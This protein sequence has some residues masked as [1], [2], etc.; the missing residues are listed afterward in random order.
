M[1]MVSA[2]GGP[3]LVLLPGL[4]CDEALWGHPARYLA[5]IAQITV[6]GIHH[7]DNIIDLA[8]AVLEEAPA[9]FA[10]AGLSMGG[11]VALEVLRQAPERVVK[12][13]LLN[14][15]ARADT[16]EQARRR[17]ALM[18]LAMRGRF[19]GV[20]QRLLSTLIHPERLEDAGLTGTI[21]AMAERLG[22]DAFLKQQAAILGRPDSRP[23]LHAIRCP[24]LVIVGRED[25]LSP[26]DRAVEMAEGIPGGK[27]A[28]IERCGHLAPLEQP[29]ATTALL[30]LWLTQM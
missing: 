26:P 27:L 23:G 20:T 30:R 14:T 5:D 19:Q 11:Y 18:A 22:R 21:T 24:T 10:L 8:R 1:A 17:R 13:A 9:R 25:A 15:N 29:E 28:I 6:A 4:L 7:H 16:A 3:P 2:A 12:L